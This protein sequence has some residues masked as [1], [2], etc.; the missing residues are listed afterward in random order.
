MLSVQGFTVSE[1]SMR[2]ARANELE[3]CAVVMVK[4]GG[5]IMKNE[6]WKRDVTE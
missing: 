1:E 5:V 2:F 4:G 6:V 3:G